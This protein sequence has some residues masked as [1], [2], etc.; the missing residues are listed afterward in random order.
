VRS[1][2]G[3]ELSNDQG[4]RLGELAQKLSS[5][6]RP[7]AD[8]EQGL[9]AES[10]LSSSPH[11]EDVRLL[12]AGALLRIR[13]VCRESSSGSKRPRNDLYSMTPAAPALR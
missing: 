10:A 7:G 6:S 2:Y 13:V 12:A 5:M 9:W 3:E 8:F 1:N 4:D 11:W